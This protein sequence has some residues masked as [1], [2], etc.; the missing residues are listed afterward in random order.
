M[1]MNRSSF[2][3]AQLS[4][5]G[6]TLRLMLVTPVLMAA[7]YQSG[8]AGIAAAN[9]NAVLSGAQFNANTSTINLG[10]VALGDTKTATITFTNSTNSAVTITNISVSGAGFNAGGI[11][12]GTILNPGQT[13]TLSVTFTSSST[14]P[15]TGSITLTSNAVNSGITVGLEATGVPAGDHLAALSWGS[16]G[17][18]AIG[19]NIYR[20]TTSGGPYARV[21]T[22][23][24]G[25]TKYTDSAVS[26]GQSYYYVV[27]SVGSN[28]AES[29]YSNEVLA[30]IPT[31]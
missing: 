14:G 27:T 29:A 12:S 5:K 20:G 25:N 15:E 31:P 8:C 17:A 24:D 26:A 23:L 30:T 11:P 4:S 7:L 18:L 1:G 10:N 9:G 21:N 22:A 13:A 19:Y 6:R 2:A 28:S 3:G 16:V